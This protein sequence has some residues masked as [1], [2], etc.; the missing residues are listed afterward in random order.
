M[1]RNVSLLE[2][3][4]SLCFHHGSYWKHITFPSLCSTQL[5]QIKY[6]GLQIIRRPVYD[7]SHQTQ[8]SPSIYNNGRTEKE[9]EDSKCEKNPYYWDKEYEEDAAFFI[10]TF[11]T[12][13]P[14]DPSPSSSST[15]KT[16]SGSLKAP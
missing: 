3:I 1:I 4:E 5:H 6:R 16:S 9:Q 2:H 8:N 12:C 10:G 13:P 15:M 14:P 7:T 11:R